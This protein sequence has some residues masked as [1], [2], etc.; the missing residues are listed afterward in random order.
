MCYN[1]SG[2]VDIPGLELKKIAHGVNDTAIMITVSCR[3]MLRQRTADNSQPGLHWGLFTLRI[4]LVHTRIEWPELLQAL[5]VAAAT[6]LGLVPI[7]TT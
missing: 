3:H 5:F 6:T 4:P 1:Y 2:Q 7:L